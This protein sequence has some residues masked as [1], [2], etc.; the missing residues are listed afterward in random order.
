ML[1][2]TRTVVT[3]AKTATATKICSGRWPLELVYDDWIG[4]DQDLCHPDLI[5]LDLDTGDPPRGELHRGASWGWGRQ[6]GF[7]HWILET[8]VW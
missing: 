5:W 1:E 7:A 8:E 3:V 2:V 4:L 6:L